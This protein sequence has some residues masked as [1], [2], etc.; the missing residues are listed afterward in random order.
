[1]RG[2]RNT[3]GNLIELL[4]LDKPIAGLILPEHA[5]TTEGYIVRFHP[6]RNFKQHYFNSIPPTSHWTWRAACGERQLRACLPPGG[7][8]VER[9]AERAFW[10]GNK[11]W[12]WDLRPS[13]WNCGNLNYDKWPYS[14]LQNNVESVC[15]QAAGRR[16][17]GD[18]HP[19]PRRTPHLGDRNQDCLTWIA[20]HGQYL[21]KIRKLKANQTYFTSAHNLRMRCNVAATQ[22]L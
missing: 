3:V 18:P 10:S 7:A 16:G 2:W 11:Q 19:G 20:W 22:F 8:R 13:I 15:G 9:F 5:W 21:I 1:M 17:M 14:R 4:W 6:I 12:F